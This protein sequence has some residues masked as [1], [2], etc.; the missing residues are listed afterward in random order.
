MRL[1]SSPFAS[2]IVRSLGHFSSSS[3]RIWLNHPARRARSPLARCQTIQQHSIMRQNHQCHWFPPIQAAVMHSRRNLAS[4]KP[5][6]IH[7]IMVTM[8]QPL[9]D[10][11]LEGSL[12]YFVKHSTA[13]QAHGDQNNGS[14]DTLMSRCLTRGL[15]TRSLESPQVQVST[16]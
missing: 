15:P 16:R 9:P 7:K 3:Q 6:L 13:H 11:L 4:R 14:G 1:L 5:V 10:V 2:T 12:K 8:R